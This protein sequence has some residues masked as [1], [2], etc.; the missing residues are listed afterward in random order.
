MRECIKLVAVVN[1]H[2][3]AGCI[4]KEGVSSSKG[5]LRFPVR[6]PGLFEEDAVQ[7][8]EQGQIGDIPT[9][10]GPLNGR[11]ASCLPALS[12]ARTR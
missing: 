10:A 9:P 1:L 7:R 2:L 5:Y 12:I 4:T 8:Q 3:Q 6:L 11:A